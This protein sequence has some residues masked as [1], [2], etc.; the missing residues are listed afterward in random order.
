MPKTFDAPFALTAEPSESAQAGP[1]DAAPQSPC[2]REPAHAAAGAPDPNQLELTLQMLIPSRT[3]SGRLA[4]ARHER[5]ARDL[6]DMAWTRA[7]LRMS[8][9]ARKNGNAQTG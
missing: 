4:R 7:R 6:L 5:A 9:S 1:I 3:A 8:R 2:S